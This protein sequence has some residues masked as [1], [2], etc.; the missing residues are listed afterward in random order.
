MSNN[1]NPEV[2]AAIE[3]ITAT[4]RAAV[5][6]GEAGA[7]ITVFVPARLRREITMR[8]GSYWDEYRYSGFEHCLGEDITSVSEE[9]DE[10]DEDLEESD[11]PIEMTVACYLPTVQGMA[12]HILYLDAFA[13]RCCEIRHNYDN[14]DLPYWRS[15][16]E[17]A[18][19]A[20]FA[21][22]TWYKHLG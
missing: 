16:A 8:L 3:T 13:A 4:C 11:M 20:A 10:D 2:T 12:W 21:L 1:T 19:Q 6:D 7:L 15:D 14:E 9:Y 17:A 22:R 18:T 5:D